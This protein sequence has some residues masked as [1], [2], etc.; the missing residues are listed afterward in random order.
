MNHEVNHGLWVI[1]MGPCVFRCN[2]GSTVEGMLVTVEVM[3]VWGQ[4]V[5]TRNRYPPLNFAVNLKPL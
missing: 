2:K 1:L 3:H 5:Y 4:R